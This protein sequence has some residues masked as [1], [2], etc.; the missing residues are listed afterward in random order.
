M[1][2]IVIRFLTILLIIGILV[3]PFYIKKTK[4]EEIHYKGDLK[5]P[6]GHLGVDCTEERV[7]NEVISVTV[8]ATNGDMVV[9]KNVRKVRVNQD[10]AEYEVS[11]HVSGVNVPLNVKKAYVVFVM[12]TSGSMFGNVENARGAI[13]EFTNKLQ[14]NV[15]VKLIQFAT[16]ASVRTEF[17]NQKNVVADSVCGYNGCGMGE[18]SLIVN[19]LNVVKNAFPS[20]DETKYVIYLIDGDYINADKWAG[21]SGA[22]N[23]INQN[24]SGVKYRA[25]RFNSLWYEGVGENAKMPADKRDSLHNEIYRV[26]KNKKGK[27]TGTDGLCK[28][29]LS[30]NGPYIMTECFK[31]I[32]DF[33][34][35]GRG[36]QA[37]GSD[38]A[39]WGSMLQQI[40]AEINA[41][42]PL[43]REVQG[44]IVDNKGDAFGKG[45]LDGPS[46]I[47]VNNI[48]FD[49]AKYLISINQNLS[50]GWYQTNNGFTFTYDNGAKSVTSQ[51]DPVVYWK[52]EE[53]KHPACS[54]ET[55][56]SSQYTENGG[57]ISN[58]AIIGQ[59]IVDQGKNVLYSPHCRDEIRS[60][61]VIGNLAKGEN[62]F[63]IIRGLG[64]SMKIALAE[65]ITCYNVWNEGLY[66]EL[67]NRYNSYIATYDNPQVISSFSRQI[68]E[69]QGINNGRKTSDTIKRG[70]ES[71]SGLFEKKLP[72][73]TI[74]YKDE[75]G[76]IKK[77]E[78]NSTIFENVDGTFTDYD[79][80]KELN[81]GIYQIKLYKVMEI[82]NRCL[83][84][85]SGKVV[86]CDITKNNQIDGDN[87]YYFGENDKYY[88][89]DITNGT[90]SVQIL[91]IGYNG[92]MDILM[93]DE[94]DPVCR[95][96]WGS[97]EKWDNSNLIY[98]Q[99]DVADPFIQQFKSINQRQIGRNYSNST[100]DF[101]NVIKSDIWSKDYEYF[102]QM[103]KNNIQNIKKD[104]IGNN[105]KANSYL[106][107]NCKIN[108]KNKYV[109]PFTRNIDSASKD[110]FTVANL[111]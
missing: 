110:F 32:V 14:D 105:E 93:E 106:G 29:E 76:N 16:N 67:I 99:I 1:R 86:E 5:C 107:T 51:T 111:K 71:Y 49:S 98:R 45:I 83:Q 53:K 30:G 65:T 56:S 87:K 37:E 40:A 61:L 25:I 89:K 75:H 35:G 20:N 28:D 21:A 23:A 59:S 69:L 13:R 66:N 97:H 80:P 9:T 57:I 64:E 17:T 78:S 109:C 108:N 46:G 55:S 100:F 24:Y 81:N 84:L 3:E 73:L 88:D 15:Y 34:V 103:S 26:I 52:Q 79:G 101:V 41:E 94:N 43:P 22:A 85:D 104:T 95:F 8:T 58:Y 68:S 18:N 92:T 38:P 60:R 42:N 7:N 19:A 90:I 74:K 10:T 63:E 12:D 2:K 82:K 77:K 50:D 4:A 47:Y 39:Q 54:G 11:F 48:I 33:L 36:N 44:Y 27:V 96:N 70:L 62:Q 72:S 91:D 6:D 102:Y 31:K